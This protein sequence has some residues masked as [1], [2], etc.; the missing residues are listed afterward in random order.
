MYYETVK[1]RKRGP[2]GSTQRFI[3]VS[4]SMML[5]EKGGFYY[6]DIDGVGEVK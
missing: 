2:Q 6:C 5:R 4:L 1:S 3:L